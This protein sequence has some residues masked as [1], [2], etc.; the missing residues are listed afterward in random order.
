MSTSLGGALADFLGR[1]LAQ[2][3]KLVSNSAGPV[4]PSRLEDCRHG[5][6]QNCLSEHG[7]VWME[8]STLAN[9]TGRP[10]FRV[11]PATCV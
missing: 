9:G 1:V 7:S 8:V 2:S 6:W 5:L 4:I 3:I 11:N 10:A